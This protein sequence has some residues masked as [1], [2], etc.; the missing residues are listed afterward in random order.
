M[1]FDYISHLNIP[2]HQHAETGPTLTSDQ[3]FAENEMK[4]EQ[5]ETAN[6]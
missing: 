5:K 6:F 1:V 2:G 3:W 4:L